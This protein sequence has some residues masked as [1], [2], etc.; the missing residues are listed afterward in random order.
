[1][2]DKVETSA[3]NHDKVEVST[4]VKFCTLWILRSWPLMCSSRKI[5]T[6]PPEDRTDQYLVHECMSTVFIRAIREDNGRYSFQG[7]CD[8]STVKGVVAILLAMFAGK[9]AT[10]IE[11]YDAHSGFEDLG[12]F[13]HLSPTKHVGVYAMVRRVK[14]Q[15][16]ALEASSPET[17][18]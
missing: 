8:T 1:M 9:T 14:R 16:R 10:K 5:P 2:K 17:R 4:R 15:V 7:D 11:Q 18:Q 6:Y 12:L 3:S 13:E